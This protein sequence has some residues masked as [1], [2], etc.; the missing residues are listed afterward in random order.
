MVKL[1][2]FKSQ[3]FWVIQYFALTGLKKKQLAPGITTR[4]YDIARRLTYKILKYRLHG[5]QEILSAIVA[6]CVELGDVMH[7]P[8]LPHSHGLPQYPDYH[9]M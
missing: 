3:V 2:H 6:R 7:A 8:Q 5:Y 1:F 9:H 4:I